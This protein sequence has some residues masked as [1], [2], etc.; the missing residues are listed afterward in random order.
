MKRRIFCRFSDLRFQKWLGLSV[1]GLFKKRRYIR[2]K[3]L[4]NYQLSPKLANRDIWETIL[5]QWG[6]ISGSYCDMTGDIPFW[7]N[8]RACLSHL[9]G[10]VWKANG[11]ALEEYSSVKGWGR[12]RHNGRIDL[13]FILNNASNTSYVVEAK[14][15]WHGTISSINKS[16][17]AAK[18][19]AVVSA[20]AED[21]E[22]AYAFVFQS[23]YLMKNIESREKKRLV[24]EDDEKIIREIK[25]EIFGSFADTE[26]EYVGG[27]NKDEYYYVGRMIGKRIPRDSFT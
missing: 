4:F 22:Q 7:Y 13:Y 2:S 14:K 6:K 9:A 16:L 5:K 15:C 12:G 20:K 19:D 18:K 25:P 24:K 11:C 26:E 10:A 8:E 3:Y 27:K 21:A 17:E 23:P 1:N